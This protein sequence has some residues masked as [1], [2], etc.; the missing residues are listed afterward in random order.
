MDNNKKLLEGLLKADGINPAGATESERIAF[1]K[2][3]DEQSESKQP[4]PGSQ[5]NIWRIIM[6]SRITK[7]AAAA[8]IIIVVLASINHFGGSLDGGSIVFADVLKYIQTQSY[9]FDLTMDPVFEDSVKVNIKAMI[10]E[11]GRV[12]MDCSVPVGEM[13]SITDFTT[14]KTLLLFHENN[15]A[16]IKEEPVLNKST[17]AQGMFVLFTRPIDNLW[18]MRDGTEEQLGEKEINGQPVTGFKV[19]QEDRYFQYEMTIWADA[20]DGVPRLVEVTSKPLDGSYSIKWTME[21]FDLD[22]DLDEELFSLEVPDGYTLAYQEDLEKLEV[23]TESSA[24]AKKIEQILEFWSQGRK[25]ETIQILLSIEW[26]E[27]IEFGKEPYLFSMTEK[28]YI[29]LKDEDQKRIWEEIMITAVA[30]RKIVFQE[31]V[32]LGQEAVSSNNYEAA[33]QYYKA[34]LQLG[35][36]LARD[37][38]AMIIVRLVG[39]AVEKVTLNEMISLYTTTN[40]QKKL[41]TAEKQLQAAEAE[42]AKIK[43]KALGR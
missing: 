5:P 26:T 16:V 34:G 1:I 36:L 42:A 32:R 15:T 25:D 3:L 29:A 19:L 35:K 41:Q 10:F 18:N 8:V 14:E 9:T 23:D 21:N 24:E 28:G 13:S 6:K 31:V 39:I 22:V 38:E 17:G 27:Q 7:L 40:N 4:K 30:V 37:P 20:A 2:M 33:E 11:L 43:N 12:R